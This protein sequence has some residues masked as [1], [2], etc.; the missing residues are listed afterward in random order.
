MN[1]NGHDQRQVTHLNASAT[2]PDISPDGTKV[3]FNANGV[4][5]D[6]N[7]DIYVTNLDGSGLTQLTANAGNNDYP[8]WSS[9]GSK[10]A[11]TSDAPVP[12]RCT[13]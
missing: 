4:N 8:A 3:A 6:S 2:I 10:I 12:S 9:D 7:D 1:A 11:F 5:G 13:S